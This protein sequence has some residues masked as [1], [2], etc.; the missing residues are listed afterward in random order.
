MVGWL[1][2]GPAICRRRPAQPVS[3]HRP[4]KDIAAFL[5]GVVQFMT[6]ATIKL[7]S[8]L[9]AASCAWTLPWSTTEATAAS[10][11]AATATTC[12]TRNAGDANMLKACPDVGS[13]PC[14]DHIQLL[15]KMLQ[16]PL[17]LMLLLPRVWCCPGLEHEQH[18]NTHY[19]PLQ[20]CENCD[21]MQ[22]CHC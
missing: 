17:L 14:P 5:P 21:F 9:E 2:D 15:A 11:A 7:M 13:K 16:L 20:W 19:P 10:A 18:R 8:N 22:G 12:S 4:G 3:R 1:P 6:S